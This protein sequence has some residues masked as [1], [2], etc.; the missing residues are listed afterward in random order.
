MIESGSESESPNPPNLS[1]RV[2]LPLKRA[3]AFSMKDMSTPK[4]KESGKD[5]VRK[6]R[7]ELFKEEEIISP[8]TR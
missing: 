3:L 1:S 4:F 7:R 5:T 2:K 6:V 8:S